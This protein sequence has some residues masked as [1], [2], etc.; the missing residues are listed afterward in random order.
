MKS[1][2]HIYAPKK[3]TAKR[4]FYGILIVLLFTLATYLFW[5]IFSQ[6]NT[7]I[8]KSRIE[9]SASITVDQVSNQFSHYVTLMNSIRSFFLANAS[10]EV[11]QDRW[12][13]YIQSQYS[14]DLYNGLESIEYIKLGSSDKA[15]DLTDRLNADLTVGETP[16][17]IYPTPL[18]DQLAVVVHT[19]GVSDVKRGYNADSDPYYRDV[20]NRA[21]V[22]S[23]QSAGQV[24]DENYRKN[25]D[26]AKE[27]LIALAIYNS[28][29]KDSMT[30]EQK[31]AALRGFLVMAVHTDKIFNQVMSVASS[32][33]QM[34][35]IVK[36]YN[37]LSLYS[38]T[39]KITEPYIE[40]SFTL[41]ASG[42]TWDLTFRVPSTYSLT[43]REQ[44]APLFF[45]VGG[46]ILTILGVSFYLYQQGFR[47]RRRP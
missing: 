9:V 17:N 41:D 26:T 10:G 27:M 19:F 32:Q 4:R 7:Q 45:L 23:S 5:Y 2:L 40:K 25:G 28:T 42:Q 34:E 39:Q 3:M 33:A 38:S 14:H 24:F 22:S 43:L 31:T 29:Y 46:N 30:I 1:R 37:G 36:T 35:M 16:I 13:T 11:N 8:A 12:N 15:I 20:L 6:S 47:I 44:Y 18:T 21:L